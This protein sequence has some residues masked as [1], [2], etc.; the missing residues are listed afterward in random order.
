MHSGKLN[1]G[2][3]LMASVRI[4][5]SAERC[6]GEWMVDAAEPPTNSVM[7]Y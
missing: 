6:G 7:A 5:T 4:T 1:R 2:E 3:K